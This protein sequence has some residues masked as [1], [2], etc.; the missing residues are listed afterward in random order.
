MKVVRSTAKVA[1]S[2]PCMNGVA[3]AC[4]LKR[5]RKLQFLVA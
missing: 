4:M 1:K 2:P 5:P 3:I